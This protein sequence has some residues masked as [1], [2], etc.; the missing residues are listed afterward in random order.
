M[1]AMDVDGAHPGP[2]SDAQPR[3][4]TVSSLDRRLYYEHLFPIKTFVRW[5]SYGDRR[6]FARRE[7]SFTK[8]IMDP[9]G[10][11]AEIYSR[12]R[13][14]E[15]A[16]D[17]QRALLSWMPEK[18]DIG[19][20]YS[21][22]PKARDRAIRFEPEQRELVFDID[23]SDY[24]NVRSCCQGKK[25]CQEC[26]HYMA[27]GIKVLDHMLAETFDFQCRLWVFS[28]RR[29]VHCWVGDKRARELT[30]EERVAVAKYLETYEGGAGDDDMK[31]TIESGLSRE[32]G[33]WMHPD[34]EEVENKFVIPGFERI[35]LAENG[36]NS[37]QCP[38]VSGRL[39]AFITAR[40][41]AK[42]V[43]GWQDALKLCTQKQKAPADA[44]REIRGALDKAKLG[45]IYHAARFAFVFPRLDVN[46]STKRNHLLKS[47]YAVHP[48]TGVVCVPVAPGEVDSF[49]PLT[50]PP[51]IGQ[52]MDLW[53][54][55]K[56][57]AVP[58]MELL[59]EF[60]S[61]IEK[62]EG[63]QGLAAAP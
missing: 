48:G 39:E 1:T 32:K 55:G 24:D 20:V 52:L 61:N 49:D 31:L 58:R 63:R 16:E 28:G 59:N 18:M 25:I 12:Y 43:G 6:T 44:W 11:S 34:L 62:Q 9:C 41:G 15:G 7:W 45:W 3:A 23:L 17:M 30:D 33:A 4:P 56:A 5:L 57:Q 10:N 53:K 21:H 60:I 54:Q 51:R 36:P 8:N 27:T 37:L 19:A 35:V 50:H 22:E 26:W 38:K 13:S 2:A 40:L 29:G 47:P 46:V 14:F 42:Q